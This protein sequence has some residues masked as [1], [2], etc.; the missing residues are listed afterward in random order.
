MDFRTQLLS[1]LRALQPVLDVKGILVIGS[2]IPNLLE[3]G[4]ASTLVIS[5]DVDIGVDVS[6]HHTVKEHLRH[7]S[8][9]R[10]STEEPSVWVPVQPDLIEVNF[11]GM[12]P[13]IGDASETYVLEDP[14]LPLLVFG[15]LSYLRPSTPLIVEGIMIPVPRPAGLI[16]EKLLTDRSAEKGARDLLVVLGLLLTSGKVDIDEL[17]ECYVQLSPE[18]RHA[19]RSNLAILSLMEPHAGMPDPG[20]HRAA[21]A[22]LLGSLEAL[23]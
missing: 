5:R 23:E 12:D 3:H 10:P 22:S 2:E 7:V 19:V 16:L 17:C 14:E 21:I 8:A 11:V 6:C 9:L 20:P 13:G 18:L 1:T 15:T 4:S